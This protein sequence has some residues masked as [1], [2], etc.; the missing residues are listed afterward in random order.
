MHVQTQTSFPSF[1]LTSKGLRGCAFK[2][3]KIESDGKNMINKEIVTDILM[4]VSLTVAP[5]LL[6]LI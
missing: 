1:N 4:L 3:L 2:K 6:A 5:I